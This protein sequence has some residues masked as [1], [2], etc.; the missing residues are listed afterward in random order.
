MKGALVYLHYPLLQYFYSI[1]KRAQ[2]IYIHGYCTYTW[3]W[4]QCHQTSIS[5][6]LFWC[7]LWSLLHMFVYYIYIYVSIVY[8]YIWS[9]PGT[10]LL[11]S[12]I[13]VW[14]T[15]MIPSNNLQHQ[16]STHLRGMT[17][18]HHIDHHQGRLRESKASVLGGFSWANLRIRREDWGTLG[19]IRGITTPPAKNP[20]PWKIF[21]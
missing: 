4:V 13:Y 14:H 16:L 10:Y 18:R 19:K 5:T 2:I 17:I 12:H 15:S 11:A 7:F 20:T 9:P 8:T 6:C 3:F 1:F 21:R